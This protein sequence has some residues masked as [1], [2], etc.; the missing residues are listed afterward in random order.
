MDE[1]F[2][3]QKEFKREV[4]L[5]KY[6]E[7]L[8]TSCSDFRELKS[9]YENACLELRKKINDIEKYI[10]YNNDM[11]ISCIEFSF[12]QG[13]NDNL[14]HFK[15]P[16]SPNFLQYDYSDCLKEENLMKKADYAEA[17]SKRKQ[18]LNLLPDDDGGLYDTIIEYQVFLNTYIPKMAHFY[19][20]VTGNTLLKKIYNEYKPD[21]N[22][23]KEYKEWL[24]IYLGLELEEL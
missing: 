5:N 3:N 10:E 12:E 2:S 13:I 11:L 16:Q 6:I 15:N 8:D 9:S 4:W 14:E 7:L 24:S 20:F 18:I 1:K 19:G 23:T 17:A 21:F 22:L